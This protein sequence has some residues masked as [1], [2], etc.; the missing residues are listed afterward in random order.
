[1]EIKQTESRASYTTSHA[2]VLIISNFDI[3]N[4]NTIVNGF[5]GAFKLVFDSIGI[6]VVRLC[7]TV[8]E[9][10]PPSETPSISQNN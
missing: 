9:L 2:A 10:R 4:M 1:M 3:S 6:E 8:T 5:E 7:R